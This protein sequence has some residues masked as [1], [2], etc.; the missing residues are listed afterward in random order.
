[1][2]SGHW[3]SFY[4][5]PRGGG[6]SRAGGAPRRLMR[7]LRQH[8]PLQRSTCGGVLCSLRN[9]DAACLAE[10]SRAAGPFCD[11]T[12]AAEAPLGRAMACRAGPR[13]ALDCEI[14]SV[15]HDRGGAGSVPGSVLVTN[16]GWMVTPHTGPAVRGLCVCPGACHPGSLG[17]CEA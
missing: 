13:R 12:G 11:G 4:S 16:H 8:V 6:R 14:A 1:M 2:H 5:A 17:L 15:Q 9:G 7:R 10:R 3:S